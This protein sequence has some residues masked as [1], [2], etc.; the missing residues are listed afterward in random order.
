M[1]SPH[2]IRDILFAFPFSAPLSENQITQQIIVPCLE[3]IGMRNLYKFRGL[4]F[5]GGRDEQGTDVEYYEMIG[6]DSFRHYTGIQVKKTN[7][8]VSAAR[9]L[10]NQ[11]NRAFYKEIVDPA[12]G[13]SYRIHRWIVATTGTISPDA[14]RHIQTDLARYGKPISFWDGVK[15][16]EYILEDF[17]SEF[18]RILQVPP[19]FAG[20]SSAGMTLWDADDAPVL[21]SDFAAT[22]WTSIDIS[23]GA[24]PGLA[25]GIL[26]SAKPIGES[27]P[28]VK[29]AVR[30]STHEILMD[31]FVSRVNPSLLKLGEGVTHI[32]AMVVE[33]DR[34]INILVNGYQEFR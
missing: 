28:S 16:G 8:S 23:H 11:G 34:P 25:I 12:N 2:Q 30:S 3:K 5:T 20:Q 6:P 27:L 26:L 33:G 13:E 4:Q 14:K 29:I 17:Y 32:E 1:M 15:V 21:T 24:P 31:S 22:D 7:I 9:E 10:I 19:M 18:V